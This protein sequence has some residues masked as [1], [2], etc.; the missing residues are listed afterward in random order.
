MLRS[1]HRDDA[2]ADTVEA[3]AREFLHALT[4]FSAS[5]IDDDV[6]QIRGFAVGDFA[7]QV[8]QTFSAERI[9]QIEQAKVVST[10]TV[11]S[12]FVESLNGDTASAF[13]VVDES[14]ANNVS[15]QRRTDVLRVEVRLIETTSGWKVEQV[16]ILQTP[17]QT[18]AA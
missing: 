12:V 9:Q 16:N 15:A 10:G 6:E 18:P 11:R 2:R 14:V 8:D 7:Q 13:G 1:E 17:A 3:T 5:T 4:N